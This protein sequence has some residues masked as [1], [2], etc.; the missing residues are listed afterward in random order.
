[1]K[2]TKTT[3][4]AEK[5][6]LETRRETLRSLTTKH[7]SLVAGGPCAHTGPIVCNTP[8]G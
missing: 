8:S 6:Q 5:K 1:M 3:K 2:T 4:K 7:L